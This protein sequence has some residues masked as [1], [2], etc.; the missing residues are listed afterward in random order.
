M[1][2][3]A[4][5]RCEGVRLLGLFRPN[6]GI[7]ITHT[8]ISVFQATKVN[9]RLGL[10]LLVLIA[11]D[12]DTIIGPLSCSLARRLLHGGLGWLFGAFV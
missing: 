5:L 9:Q 10:E 4:L 6:V 11:F 2:L 8:M 3:L 12:A 1:V 7:I